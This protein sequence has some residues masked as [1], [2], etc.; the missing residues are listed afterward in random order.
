MLKTVYPEHKWVPWH[1]NKIPSMVLGDPE[2]IRD[3]LDYIES[4]KNL[5]ELESWYQISNEDLRSLGVYTIISN[6]GGLC[7]V[8]RLYRPGIPWDEE[9]FIGAKPSSQQS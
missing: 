2:V 6:A 7:S 4:E 9:L 1:F 5:T 8:L 3:C